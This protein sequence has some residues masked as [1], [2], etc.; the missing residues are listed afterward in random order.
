MNFIKDIFSK[1]KKEHF[2]D[3]TDKNTV[4]EHTNTRLG[5]YAN[6]GIILLIIISVFLV[7]FES[8]G[9]NG[10]KYLYI[11]FYIDLVISLLFL[12]EYI[13]RF[14][15]SDHK[16]RFPFR[17]TNIFDLLSFLPFFIITLF[18]GIG[19][20]IVFSLF[21]MFRVLKIFELFSHVPILLKLIRGIY[22]YKFEYFSAISIIFI[23]LVFFST[24]IYYIENFGGKSLEFS[25]I[26]ATMWWATVTMTTVGYGDMVPLTVIGKVLGGLLMFLGPVVIAII[27][28]ITVFVF[29]E[30]TKLIE[31]G[32]KSCLSCGVGN[33]KNANFCR[34]CGNEFGDD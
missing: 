9:D 17:I 21:R 24:A 1:K 20:Y 14:F 32:K 16:K 3:D 29:L 6:Y 4:F 23:I 31:I 11:I 7:M 33:T 28:A 27:S 10:I 5:R 22:R 8:I 26:P 34:H 18:F 15:H 12:I 30:A 2:V 19:N 13:Y 25:S